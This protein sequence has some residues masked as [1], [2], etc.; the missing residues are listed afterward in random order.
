MIKTIPFSIEKWK[1]GLKPVTKDGTEVEQLTRFEY[2]TEITEFRGVVEGY[3][4]AFTHFDL[5]LLEEVREPREWFMFVNCCGLLSH[6]ANETGLI[7]VREVL[8]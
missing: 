6:V 1:E 5:M 2:V 7:K 4:A 3:I 8:E